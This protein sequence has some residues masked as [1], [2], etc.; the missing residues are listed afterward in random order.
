MTEE[1]IIYEIYYGNKKERGGT[2]FSTRDK[3]EAYKY[4]KAHSNLGPTGQLSCYVKKDDGDWEKCF[5]ELVSEAY[6]RQKAYHQM[7]NI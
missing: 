2:L 1:K 7:T 6:G 4:A 5:N 3:D